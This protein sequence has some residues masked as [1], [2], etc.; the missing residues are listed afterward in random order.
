MV[1]IDSDRDSGMAEFDSDR[2]SGM[3]E[4]DSDEYDS[5]VELEI[6]TAYVQLCIEYVQKYYMKRP[7]CTSILSGRSYVIEVLEGNPQVCYDIFRMEKTIFR[8]LCNELKRLHLLEEDTGWV[9]VEESV[10]TVLFIVGHNADYRVAA[11]RFQHSLRPFKGGSDVPCV[12]SC[13]GMY[14][15]PTRR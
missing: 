2:D 4:S 1:D 11:N 13:F 3:A 15:H 9:S 14:H 7:M 5:E 10:G 8:H 6:A 12:L